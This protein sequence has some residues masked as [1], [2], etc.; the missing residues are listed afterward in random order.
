MRFDSTAVKLIGTATFLTQ[1]VLYMG[2]VLF[3]PALALKAVVD[4]P[5]DTSMIVIGLCAA[6]YTSI[7]S[8]QLH[9]IMPSHTRLVVAVAVETLW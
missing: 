6:F 3:A 5:V 1:I 9:L 4:F 8:Q 2:V 7:V